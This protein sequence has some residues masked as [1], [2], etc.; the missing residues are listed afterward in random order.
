[1][2]RNPTKDAE[3]ARVSQEVVMSASRDVSTILFNFKGQSRAPHPLDAEAE[4]LLLQ[5]LY[6]A[7]IVELTSG[8][9]YG[10]VPL[11]I[12]GPAE[13]EAASAFADRA[14]AELKR[15]LDMKYKTPFGS[16]PDFTA[17]LDRYHILARGYAEKFAQLR[18]AYAGSVQLVV[19]GPTEVEAMKD[20]NLKVL[21][22]R[23]GKP[24]DDALKDARIEWSVNQS[25][26]NSGPTWWFSPLQEST[27]TIT[28][29]A[30]KEI[31]GKKVPLGSTTHQLTGEEARG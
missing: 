27:M 26:Q 20:V 11:W 19:D 1:M 15:Q 3:I 2:L 10:M 5:Y 22:K 4:G 14:R 30:F 9:T 28:I 13:K 16:P 12:D 31:M 7:R 18:D 25:V 17:V 21:A 8:I 24:A 29:T 23:A 6:T